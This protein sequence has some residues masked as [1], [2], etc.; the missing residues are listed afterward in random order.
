M[1]NYQCPSPA[2]IARSGIEGKDFTY[3]NIVAYECLGQMAFARAATVGSM[4]GA[5]IESWKLLISSDLTESINHSWG[6]Y[7]SISG[8]LQELIDTTAATV[9]SGVG[10]GNAALTGQQKSTNPTAN[11]SSVG[12]A[13]NSLND[14][15]TAGM[16]Q[17]G[18]T[19]EPVK[20]TKLDSS[21]VYQDS[22]NRQFS[23][24]LELV[25]YEDARK[26][27]YEP[28]R[29]FMELSC[30]SA[31]GAF[32]IDFPAIFS[33]KSESMGGAGVVNINMA[34]LIATQP[35]WRFPWKDGY[36]MSA[37]ITLTFLEIPPL[38]R[39]TLNGK[40]IVTS[41]KETGLNWGKT[42]VG[43]GTE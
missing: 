29:A 27:V 15:L 42:P 34:A 33:L 11:V 5:P 19:S 20:N 28:I 38:Y 35:T 32:G 10:V 26:E 24:E 40:S 43:K 25:A 3:L 8:K 18:L 39:Q 37:S 41:S 31:K 7:E 9:S 6:K 14:L 22:T 13:G 21:V 36:P 4:R 2:L 1:N 30:A 23:I 17:M 12:A 16:E